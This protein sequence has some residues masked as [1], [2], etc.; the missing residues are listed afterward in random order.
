MNNMKLGIYKL[1][2]EQPQIFL[3]LRN[4]TKAIVLELCTAD[5]KELYDGA[6]LGIREDGRLELYSS[7]SSRG[8]IKTDDIGKIKIFEE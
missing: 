4:A 3:R 7:L 8:V 1:K 6:I 5:G 2:E